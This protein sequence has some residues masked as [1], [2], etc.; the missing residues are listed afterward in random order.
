MKTALPAFALGLLVAFGFEPF[1][2]WP[3]TLVGFGGIAVLASRA[4]SWRGAFAYG[5]WFGVG[6][7]VL[8]LDWIATAFTYQ[9][10]M[11]ARLGWVAVVLLSLYLA[12][13]PGLATLAAWWVTRRLRGGAA[14]FSLA[15]GAAWIATEWA[16][17]TLFT[18]FPWNPTAVAMI[19]LP[20]A[21][22]SRVIGTYAL[23]GVIVASAGFIG[24]LAGTPRE[25][26]G[27]ATLLR[28]ANLP[29]GVGLAAL[30]A[31]YF[32]PGVAQ[33]I[34]RPDPLP[35]PSGPL[36]TIVQPNIGQG[37]RW[38]PGLAQRHLD[39]EIALSGTPR[40]TPRL[41]LWPESGIEDNVAE[42][43]A[44][45]RA[46][47]P[48]IGPRDVL[49]SGAAM[50]VRDRAGEMVAARNSVFAFDGRGRVLG[51]YDKAHLVPYGEYLP[52]RPILSAIGV[53]RLAPGELDFLPGPGART[54]ALPGGREVGVQICYE[55][56]FS[57]KVVE[58][59]HRP[60]FLFNPSNDAWFGRSGPPQHLAQARLR[61]IEEGLPVA[62]ATPT[63]IS[64]IITADGRVARDLGAHAAGMMTQPMPAALPPTSF[65]VLGNWAAL[66]V[67]LALAGLA[68]AA[69]S[70]KEA[71]I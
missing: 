2:L 4:T 13:F 61:A 12:L 69:K 63:G 52:M 36:V 47:L 64:A 25:R 39:R 55:I 14:T 49:L 20:V 17:G 33:R 60:D 51:R 3:L 30:L 67:T 16:R 19:D 42:D 46:I 27:R 9:A 5:W 38:D 23:S 40:A 31:L 66:A 43:P 34:G 21:H 41:L 26:L 71:F 11:P 1:A 6:Q 28:R 29:A 35:T 68:F 54:L 45:R 48:P 18:G 62:R 24:A 50:P 7:F 44:V 58:P 57:G 37:E 8:G 53:S 59:G 56:V 32:I 70:Y 15:F 10:N 22:L 65:S